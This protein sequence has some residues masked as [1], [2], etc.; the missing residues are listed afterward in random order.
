MTKAEMQERWDGLQEC[1]VSIIHQNSELIA[2]REHQVVANTEV[3]KALNDAFIHYMKNENLML[4]NWLD[5]KHK[6]ILKTK[7]HRILYITL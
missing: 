6:E 3:E 1:M 7:E 4:Y 2:V 5:R